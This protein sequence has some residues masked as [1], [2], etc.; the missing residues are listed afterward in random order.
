MHA[1]LVDGGVEAAMTGPL[2]DS[3]ERHALERLTDELDNAAWTVQERVHRGTAS[4]DE[5][6]AAFRRARASSAW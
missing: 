4:R 3:P 6:F 1:S 2:G 5:Y